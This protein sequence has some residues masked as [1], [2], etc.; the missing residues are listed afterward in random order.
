[1]FYWNTVTFIHLCIVHGCSFAI[2][3]KLNKCNRETRWSTNPKIFTIWPFAE[4]V[5]KPLTYK[6]KSK[7]LS[8]KYKVY[9]LVLANFPILSPAAP[10]HTAYTPNMP[11]NF[12]SLC[13]CLFLFPL[14]RMKAFFLIYLCPP[15]NPYTFF[16]A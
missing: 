4:K 10:H 16:K 11:K 7:F 2:M 8:I 9:N 13:L 3:A 15:S 6:I 5:C 14:S 12:R 1:M